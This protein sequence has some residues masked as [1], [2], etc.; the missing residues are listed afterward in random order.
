MKIELKKIL[1]ISNVDR[2]AENTFYNQNLFAI[3]IF[4]YHN[5]FLKA[6][7]KHL[8]LN[9]SLKEVDFNKKKALPFFFSIRTSYKKKMY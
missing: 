7:I 9:F 4:F 5:I 3:S 2:I 6:Q 8:T 1:S